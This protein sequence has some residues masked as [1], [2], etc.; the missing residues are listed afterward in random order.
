MQDAFADRLGINLPM[1]HPPLCVAHLLCLWAE[2]CPVWHRFSLGQ[3]GHHVQRACL[4]GRLFLELQI[5]IYL[6]EL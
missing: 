2:A 4:R 6:V 1:N 5:D 3:A